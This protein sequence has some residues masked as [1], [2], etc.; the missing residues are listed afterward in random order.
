MC[1]GNKD[2]MSLLELTVKVPVCTHK[3]P[4]VPVSSVMRVNVMMCEKQV[5]SVYVAT[6]TVLVI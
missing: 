4:Y 2:K 1:L 3:T 5:G 6:I